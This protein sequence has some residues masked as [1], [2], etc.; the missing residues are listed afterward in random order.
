MNKNIIEMNNIVKSFYIG[1]PN[2]LNVLKGID[3]NLYPL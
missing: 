1:T 3:I 2:Q